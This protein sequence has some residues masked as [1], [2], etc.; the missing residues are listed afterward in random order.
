MPRATHS[1]STQVPPSVEERRALIERVAG[2]ELFGRSARLR[3]FLL[4]VGRQSLNEGSSEIHEQEIGVRVFGR[5]ALYDRSQD[6][7]VR[8][9][10]T[11][12]RKRVDAYFSGI[13]A[14]EPLVFEIPRGGYVPVFLRRTAVNQSQPEPLSQ[15]LAAAALT[16]ESDTKTGRL[17]WLIFL[18]W[19]IV[20]LVPIAMCGFLLVQNR[21]LETSLHPWKRNPTL[22][23]FWNRFLAPG[24]NTDII[25]PDSSVSLNEELTGQVLTL[26]EYVGHAYA[27]Q[28]QPS[29]V[30]ADRKA[31]LASIFSH[32]L[33]TFGDLRAAQQILSLEPDSPALQLASARF[34]GS[35]SIKRDNVILIGGKKANPWV[36]L[37]DEEMNF[38][39]EQNNSTRLMY[40]TNRKPQDGESAAYNEH[41]EKK[42]PIGYSIAAYLP[43]PGG[44]GNAI[45]LAGTSADATNA[46]AEFLTSGEQMNHFLSTIHAKAFP[47]FEILL[48][49]SQL[50][51][52]SF[53]AEIVAYRTHPE[54]PQ[55]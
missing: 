46:A 30:S 11:E 22:A 15:A 23:A 53:H 35:D 13:G 55:K 51:G 9:N 31:D 14:D 20:T 8:V 29:T 12:L 48:R 36:F 3:D 17:S 24:Q 45:I 40:V 25:L 10:A 27:Q 42:G 41:S 52:T 7:I 2:S 1:A 26:N 33:I 43:D 21:K 54:I 44:T 32:N 37:F 39:L 50:S 4:Y 34:Y 5:P 28:V 49:T 47:Y 19:G 6:N 38:S 18:V 16:P